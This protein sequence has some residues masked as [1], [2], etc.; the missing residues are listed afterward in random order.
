VPRCPLGFR[1][2]KQPGRVGD[3]IHLYGDRI[4]VVHL[5]QSKD[6][7][8]TEHLM[9]GDVDYTPLARKLQAIHFDGPLYIE[10]RRSRREPAN[11]VDRRIPPQEPRVGEG[12]FGV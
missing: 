7:V 12:V 2:R 8:W 10:F 6:G 11:D 4:A 1:A 9:P 5:R 3:V